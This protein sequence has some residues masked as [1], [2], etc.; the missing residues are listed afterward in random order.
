GGRVVTA[1]RPFRGGTDF[2]RAMSELGTPFAGFTLNRTRSFFRTRT[3]VS[4]AVDLRR[5]IE[6]F[7]DAR[8]TGQLG[9]GLGLQ[10][11]DQAALRQALR[12]QLTVRVPGASK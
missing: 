3:A 12:F 7:G 6:A 8:L 5:G 10:T 2:G 9:A 11:D 4:G 1:T